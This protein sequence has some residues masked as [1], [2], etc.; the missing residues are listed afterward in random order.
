MYTLLKKVTI[1]DRLIVPKTVTRS[2]KLVGI[3]HL[4]NASNYCI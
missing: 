4:K 3:V 2:R 1:F